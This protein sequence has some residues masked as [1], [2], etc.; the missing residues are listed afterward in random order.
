MLPYIQYLL[1]KFPFDIVIPP[2][3]YCS[4]TSL[5]CV[6]CFC[7]SP[8]KYGLYFTL[9]STSQTDIFLCLLFLPDAKPTPVDSVYT[10][11]IKYTCEYRINI[12]QSHCFSQVVL[13]KLFSKNNINLSLFFKNKMKKKYKNAT[14][15]IKNMSSLGGFV[16]NPF[17]SGE[18]FDYLKIPKG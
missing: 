6:F 12:G 10:L 17:S 7:Q 16:Y 3:Q 1:N 15:M 2:V 8:H 18:Q 5:L 9:S 4:A 11:A 14:Q 13:H